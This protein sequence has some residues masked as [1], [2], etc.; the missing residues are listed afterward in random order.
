MAQ[1]ATGLAKGPAARRSSGTNGAKRASA[2]KRNA[3]R[4]IPLDLAPLLVPYKGH[5]RLAL[6]VEHMPLQ[7]RLSRGRNNGDNTWSLASDEL[8]DLEF[9]APEGSDKTHTLAIRI[10]ARDGGE[11]STVAVLDLPVSP[12]G[13]VKMPVGAAGG[14]GPPADAD[15]LRALQDE[16]AKLRDE[17]SAREA[18]LGEARQAAEQAAEDAAR[19]DREA[20]SARARET[21]LEKA[22]KEAARAGDAAAKT[23][24]AELARAR[25]A[26]DAETVKRLAAATAQAA[27]ELECE[28]AAWKAKQ[29]AEIAALAAR[30][31]KRMAEA[32]TSWEREAAD[33]LAKAEKTWKSEEAA[34]LT[35][36]K[37][38]WKEEAA[39]E[40]DAARA[41]TDA[42]RNAGKTELEQL[43]GQLAQS[44][45]ALADRE[46]ALAAARAAAAQEDKRRREEAEAALAKAKESWKAEEAARLAAGEARWRKEAGSALEVLK[47]RCEKAETALADARK[48]VSATDDEARAEL[49]RLREDLTQAK[50]AL[51]ERDAALREAQSAAEEAKTR[52]REDGETALSKARAAWKMEEA[53]RLAEAQAQWKAESERALADM[54]ARCERAEAA[55]KEARNNAEAETSGELSRVRDELAAAQT[56]LAAREQDLARVRSEGEEAYRR[57]REDAA[58]ALAKAENAWT[59]GEAER[60]AEAEA[61]GRQRDDGALREA[62]ARYRAAEQALAE[63]R[64]RSR[65]VSEPGDPNMDR[66]HDEIARLQAMLAERDAELARLRDGS[67]GTHGIA[68]AAEDGTPQARRNRGLVR[69]VI[70]VMALVIAA[71][72]LYPKIE[73]LIWPQ[74]TITI[75]DEE[76]AA[77]ASGP[78]RAASQS[79]PA[80]GRHTAVVARGVNLRAGPS[81]SAKVVMTL[82]RGVAVAI[83]E[84]RGKWTHVRLLAHGNSASG[85]GWV[86]NTYLKETAGAGTTKAEPHK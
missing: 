8:E 80:A 38:R 20:A 34:R 15:R 53:G 44:Q 30:A 69:D 48:T 10:I 17:L 43:R 68:S 50:A 81:T 86:Y 11:A 63:M 76:D 5:G 19:K 75:V 54:S 40:L 21:E 84:E 67:A 9:L 28:R 73:T 32:R 22:Q 26:W 35:A 4:A 18:E 29:D 41:S 3:L 33:A 58:E 45:A 23:H 83:L 13:S 74:P 52:G 60:L 14:A 78:H 77:N 47:A 7:S 61:R 59:A 6:R 85:E 31:D 66:L 12:D 70:L 25:E 39:K 57:W 27:S 72:M 71:I 37:T 16:L 79:S 24:E 1:R 42:A 65:S 82:E 2:D 56:A 46:K 55:L 64:M 51:E 49:R 62:T 36:A